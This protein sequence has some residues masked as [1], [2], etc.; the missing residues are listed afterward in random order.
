MTGHEYENDQELAEDAVDAEALARVEGFI[1]EI[2]N[3]YHPE[4]LSQ[5]RTLLDQH[6]IEEPE[7]LRTAL[8]SLLNQDLLVLSNDRRLHVGG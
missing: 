8:W 5:L 7:L 1:L 3:R 2:A 6:P 4:S